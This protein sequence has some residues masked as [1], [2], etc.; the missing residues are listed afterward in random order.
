VVA[1]DNGVTDFLALRSALAS[2]DGRGAVFLY[3]FDLLQLDGQDRCL[4]RFQN[5]SGA[6]QGPEDMLCD[7]LD[8]WKELFSA[9]RH[10]CS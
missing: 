4:R 10:L 7:T 3:A 1:R 2:R 5:V 8:S 6:R 9:R